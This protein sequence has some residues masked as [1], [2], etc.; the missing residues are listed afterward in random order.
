M[1]CRFR[2]RGDQRQRGCPSRGWFVFLDQPLLEC[3]STSTNLFIP[4]AIVLTI[5]FAIGPFI[6][7]YVS[8]WAIS[9]LLSYGFCFWY[10]LA[11]R[12]VDQTRDPKAPPKQKRGKGSGWRFL[13][14]DC[15]SLLFETNALCFED[16]H[17]H[18]KC[19]FNTQLSYRISEMTQA[20]PHLDIVS[21]LSFFGSVVT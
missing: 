18:F 14:V 7:N 16:L 3:S 2:K 12:N 21:K 4:E 17:H 6:R 20:F 5:P 15:A 9:V 10:F 11:T 13:K 8:P 19:S 1:C